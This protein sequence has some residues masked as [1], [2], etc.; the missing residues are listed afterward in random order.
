MCPRLR[1]LGSARWSQCGLR[2]MRSSRMAEDWAQCGRRCRSR[3]RAVKLAGSNAE[4]EVSAV[5]IHSYYMD[6]V[7]KTVPLYHRRIRPQSA[8]DAACVFLQNELGAKLDK[9]QKE[10]K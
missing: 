1:S 3:R 2:Q 4:F 8:G 10:L 9:I 5:Q 7:L 6:E